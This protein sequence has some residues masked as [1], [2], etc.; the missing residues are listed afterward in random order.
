MTP[1]DERDELAVFAC[2]GKQ[3]FKTYSQALRVVRE[4]ARRA[5]SKSIKSKRYRATLEAYR[6]PVCDQWHLGNSKR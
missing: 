1:G 4:R 6:C 3:R 5:K 2:S